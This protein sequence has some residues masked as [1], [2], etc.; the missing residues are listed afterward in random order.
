MLFRSRRNN[1]EFEPI[2]D[3]EFI[4]D[5]IIGDLELKRTASFQSIQKGKDDLIHRNF[6]KIILID[7]VDAKPADG[8]FPTIISLQYQ[9]KPKFKDGLSP[10]AD[11]PFKTEILRLPTT[12]N[13]TQTPKLIAAGIALSPYL[14]NEEYSATEVRTRFLWL[15]FDKPPLDKNDS[16]FCRVL[17]YSPDQL[18]S[19]NHPSLMEIPQE[20]PL[21]LD[22]EYIRVATPDSSQDDNGLEAMQRMEKSTDDKRYFYLLPL[23]AGLHHESVELFGMFT[24]E[25]RYGHTNEIW[26]TAQGR[27]GRALRV[28]GLQHPAPSLSSMVNRNEKIIS[29]N[30][31]YATAV[32]KGKNVTS[33]PPKTS[34]WALLYAQVKQADGLDF[35]N[36]LLSELQLKPLKRKNFEEL[37]KSIGISLEKQN[38]VN[39]RKKLPT[40]NITKELVTQNVYQ[41]MAWD[42]ESPRHAFGR[43]TNQEVDEMLRL[44]GLPINSSLSVICVEVFGQI[45]NAF[46]HID[47][48]DNNKDAIVEEASQVFN[49]NVANEL[50]RTLKKVVP[51]PASG[52]ID[53]LN[54]QLG[55]FRILR[56]SPLTE[57]PFICTSE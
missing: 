7:V 21:S 29:V 13:P 1:G 39:K 43:W 6:T 36:I 18:I 56:T 19:N 55:L 47:N 41:Q 50:N 2:G 38:E 28:A 22:P 51:P 54:S 57:V 44:Y 15:E 14:R 32:Y 37:Y 9:V 20:S 16:I 4:R 25:F 42:K 53:P 40:I 35:R 24:Y 30:A 48:F 27:F 52:S 46:E 31:P 5:L 49:Y 17:A 33:S 11:K 3:F 26:S 23:P 34:I 8:D 45:T 12:I 10:D